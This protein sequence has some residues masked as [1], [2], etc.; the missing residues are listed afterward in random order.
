MRRRPSRTLLTLAMAVAL[1]LPALAAPSAVGAVDVS[2][3]ILYAPTSPVVA[4]AS[5]QFTAKVDPY[6]ANATV[7]WRVNGVLFATDL[8]NPNGVSQV[9]F[10][11]GPGGY[12]VV[13]TLVGTDDYDY[14]F[15][16]TV[17]LQ[18][19]PDPD[20][21]PDPARLFVIA[22]IAG[23]RQFCVECLQAADRQPFE[24]GAAVAIVMN[25]GVVDAKNFLAI[26]RTDDHRHR[27]A[28]EQQPERR[29]ALPGVNRLAAAWKLHTRL[30]R[31]AERANDRLPVW[32]PDFS[33]PDLR[34]F[35]A[36]PA[37]CAPVLR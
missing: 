9:S 8:T 30:R 28:V 2:I 26:R 20:M 13:A 37:F 18:V 7:E 4:N 12:G 22:M 1:V 14:A 6:M 34:H 35:D 15:S 29:L 5:E 19:D 36:L 17:E 33:W 31:P 21:L 11:F 32:F 16:E 10:Q 24:L 3:Q 27:V 23:P 25:R